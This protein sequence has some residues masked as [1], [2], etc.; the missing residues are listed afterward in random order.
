MDIFYSVKN[1]VNLFFSQ[2]WRTKGR[3]LEQPRIIKLLICMFLHT[4]SLTH[5]II[6]P[7]HNTALVEECIKQ[8]PES[9]NCQSGT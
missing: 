6:L 8:F 2:W 9:G 4:A 1:S 5:R 7:D 3:I